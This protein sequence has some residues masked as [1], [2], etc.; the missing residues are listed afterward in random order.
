MLPLYL[1]SETSYDTAAVGPKYAPATVDGVIVVT[2]LVPSDLDRLPIT[3]PTNVVAVNP[4][5]AKLALNAVFE[6][7]A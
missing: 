2:K 1:S 3:L 4:P 5:F 7:N 6:F